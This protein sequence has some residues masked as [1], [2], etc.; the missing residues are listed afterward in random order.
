MLQ[1]FRRGKKQ[2]S[3]ESGAFKNED[4]IAQNNPYLLVELPRVLRGWLRGGGDPPLLETQH[5][6][7]D[8]GLAVVEEGEGA[9]GD[10]DRLASGSLVCPLNGNFSAVN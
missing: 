8:C 6:A 5:R 9:L 2:S 10:G 7:T 3:E 1:R 4:K